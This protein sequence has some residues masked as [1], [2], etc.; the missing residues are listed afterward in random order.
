MTSEKKQYDNQ[1]VAR[2]LALQTLNNIDN[3]SFN[4]I[5]RRLTDIIECLSPDNMKM[6]AQQYGQSYYKCNHCG[7]YHLTKQN[8]YDS[9]M[10]KESENEK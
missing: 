9:I 1:T 4:D 8:T 2:R 10:K 3:L 6:K 5:K 7:Y